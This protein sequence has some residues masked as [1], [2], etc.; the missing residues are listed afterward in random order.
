MERRY[1]RRSIMRGTLLAG[2][3]VTA[4][5]ALACKG[6]TT[7]SSSKSSSG[8]SS[9]QGQT[10]VGQLAGLDGRTGTEPKGPPVKGGTLNWYLSGNPP[11]LDPTQ[12]VSTL[13]IYPGSAVYSRLFRYKLNFDVV[14]SLNLETDSDLATSAESPDAMTWTV[15]LRPNAKFQNIAPVNGHAVEAEDVKQSFIKATSPSAANATNLAYLDA[16]QIQTPDKQTVVFK[17]NYPFSLFVA[18]GLASRYCWIFPRE[19][20]AGAFNTTSKAIGAGP[21]IL[22]SVTPDVAEVYKKNPDYYVSGQPYIDQVRVAILPDPNARIAQFT[23]GHTDYL[24][25]PLVNDVPA[26]QQQNPKA[27]AIHSINNANGIMY[28]NLGDPQSPFQD[29]RLRQAVSLAI[30]RDAYAKASGFPPG[31]YIQTFIVA[32]AIGKWAVLMNDLPSDVQ[33]G[34][35]YDPQKAKQLFDAAGGSK[36]TTKLYYP[37][38]NPADPQLGVQAQTV[39]S[40]L[41][42]TLGWNL[43]YVTIDYQREWINGGK[44]IGY[45]GGGVPADGMAWWG[46]GAVG[47]TVDEYVYT[48]YDS[49]GSQNMSHMNDPQVDAMI[50]KARATLKEDDQVKA[51]KDVQTYIISKYYTLL[52]NVNGEGYTFISQR[53]QNYLLGD[54]V[55]PGVQWANMWLTS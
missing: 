40:M 34:Y 55:A 12:N 31:Q 4:A 44:G 50:A 36:L 23:G 8:S 25:G 27:D 35:K 39:F 47:P 19:A 43:T 10:S 2:A 9:Q 13:T 49:K 18:S 14:Q 5:A 53:A 3:G 11:T 30:D 41:K 6:S 54:T 42:Q 38:G 22:D 15:K 51:Y 37:A 45:P 20:V 1:T 24:M 26:I 33:Q 46:P 48:F 29:I 21:W 32:P 7:S 28:Y 17:L 52:G 16:S